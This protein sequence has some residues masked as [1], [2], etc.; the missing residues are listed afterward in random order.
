MTLVPVIDVN[1]PDLAAL[2][3]ACRDHG[4][5]LLGGHGLDG[6]IDD[7][8][9]AAERFFAAA[10]DTK[11]GVRRTLDRPLGYND[12]ELTKRRRDHK[13]VF[14][15]VD[16]DNDRPVDPNRWPDVDGFRDQM[17]RHFSSFSELA[18]STLDLVY[19]ALGA[20][21]A[22]KES[23]PGDPSTSAMR[24]NH[25][26]T[27]DPVPADQRGDLAPLGDVALGHHTD[28][29]VLTLL[30]QDDVGG[31]QAH[32]R[33]HGWIDIEP[34]DG[35]IVVNLADSLQVWTNDQYRAAIHRVTPMT[36]RERYSIPYFLNPRHDAI[37]EPVDGLYDGE[38]VYR[39]FTW[40]EF[41]QGR[42]DDNFAD[43]GE[44]DIQIDRFRL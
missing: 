20:D 33:E 41:M 40:R 23:R 16:P 44:E 15:F 8:W 22:V 26:L 28:S 1:E 35:T 34:E 43:A 6:V 11:D 17:A 24:L 18:M 31:L 19:D 29:G 27:D 37:L 38:P 32:S 3:A 21:D 12:R 13:E 2:D 7:S 42:N 30:L 9:K 39:S 36:A 10:A 5:F 4:F 25:Y 14:D